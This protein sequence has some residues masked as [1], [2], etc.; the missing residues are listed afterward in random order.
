[1]LSIIMDM[2]LNKLWELVMDRK[3]WHAA[4]LRGSKESDM[5]EWLKTKQNK[6]V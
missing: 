4:S 1:M 6:T 3:S 5:T 2:N